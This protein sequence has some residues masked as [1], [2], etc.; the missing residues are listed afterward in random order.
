M[1]GGT[2]TQIKYFSLLY[3]YLPRN[4]LGL[5]KYAKNIV[6]NPYT[7]CVAQLTNAVRASCSGAFMPA[8]MSSHVHARGARLFLRLSYRVFTV[9][10]VT[11]CLA[12]F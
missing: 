10:L 6:L 5:S 7:K 8:V 9:H 3:K 12:Q 2:L 11:Q 1:E 4:N